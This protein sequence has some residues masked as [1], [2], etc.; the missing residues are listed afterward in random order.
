MHGW[1]AEHI[2][3]GIALRLHID[4]ADPK[5]VAIDLAVEA[6]I[7]RTEQSRQ[8]ALPAVSHAQED[9]TNYLLEEQRIVATQSFEEL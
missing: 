9:R 3:V 7:A 1:P 2:G 6:A 5:F 4:L 8:F